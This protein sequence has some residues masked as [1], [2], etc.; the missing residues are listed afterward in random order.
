MKFWLVLAALAFLLCHNSVAATFNNNIPLSSEQGS[1]LWPITSPDGLE[2]VSNASSKGRILNL[3]TPS[4]SRPD[5]LSGSFADTGI[6]L[7]DAPN[8]SST[9]SA[10]SPFLQTQFGS[11]KATL[12]P[13]PSTATLIGLA[14]IAALTRF[15]LSKNK[16]ANNDRSHYADKVRR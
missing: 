16:A 1:A 10:W 4:F 13:E 11:D 3:D 5:S 15:L 8:A 6:H 14:A 7:G 9:D 2:G 12:T